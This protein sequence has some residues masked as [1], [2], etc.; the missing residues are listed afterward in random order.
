VPLTYL[1][2]SS[3]IRYWQRRP[4]SGCG[5]SEPLDAAHEGFA[6]VATD[7]HLRAV[8]SLLGHSK[9][10]STVSYLDIEVDDALELAE[11]TDV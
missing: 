5:R 9:L 7:E 10:E 6:D 3:K 4:S 2:P 11:Q 8:Q 1:A